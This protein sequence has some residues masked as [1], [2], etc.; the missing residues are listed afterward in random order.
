[1]AQLQLL[2]REL[3][4]SIFGKM[5]DANSLASAAAVCSEWREIIMGDDTDDDR[6]IWR[7]AIN[8]KWPYFVIPD[9]ISSYKELYVKRLNWDLCLCDPTLLRTPTPQQQ[10]LT[11]CIALVR[12]RTTAGVVRAVIT[13]ESDCYLRFFNIDTQQVMHKVLFPNAI[14]CVGT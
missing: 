8:A 3:L 1:M 12:L 5:K 13:G 11:T 9:N 4:V 2:P 14:C 7:P 10:R 6:Q